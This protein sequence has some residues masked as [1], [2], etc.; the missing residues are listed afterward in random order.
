MQ[1]LE[2]VRKDAAHI[3]PLICLNMRQVV[4]EAAVVVH[5]QLEPG[6]TALA[7]KQLK[8]LL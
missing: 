6:H 8:S 4:E 2:Q 5:G 1:A 7:E 3:L